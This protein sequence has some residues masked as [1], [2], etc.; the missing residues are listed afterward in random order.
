MVIDASVL[1]NTLFPDEA[2]PQA[3]ALIRDYVADFFPLK[4]PTLL[5][6]ELTNAIWQGVRRQ[7]ITPTQAKV[8][9]QTSDSLRIELES[10]T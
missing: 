3:Q 1:L 8:M 10:V 9:L 5:T 6:Y 7:R 4:A 2:Q